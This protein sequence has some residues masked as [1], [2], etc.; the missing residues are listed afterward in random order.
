MEIITPL[1][2]P[3]GAGLDFGE[4]DVRH[5]SQGDALNTPGLSNPTRY[6]AQ[7][8]NLMTGKVNELVAQV[9]NRE[10]FVPL[11]IM[12]TILPR[13]TET[14]VTNYR[15]PVGFEARV[16]NAAVASTPASQDVVLSISYNSTY[17]GSTGDELVST[18]GEYANGGGSFSAAGELIVTLNNRSGLTLEVIASVMLTIRPVGAEAA[19]LTGAVIQGP[20]GPPGP[21]GPPG[22]QGPAGTGGAGAPG[23]VWRGPWTDGASYVTNDVASYYY[24]GT[25]LSSFIARTPHVASVLNSPQVDATT[26]NPVALGGAQ[27][28]VGPAGPA[29]GDPTL[30]SSST[31][32]TFITGGDYVSGGSEQFGYAGFPAAST[33][34]PIQV[35]ETVLDTSTQRMSMLSNVFYTWFTGHGTVRLPQTGTNEGGGALDYNNTSIEVF[36]VDNG[37]AF[38]TAGTHSVQAYPLNDPRDFIVHVRDPQPVKVAIVINGVQVG[39]VP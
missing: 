20:Q 31:T 11:P 15:I 28:A 22:P 29:G 13:N 17:G 33:A 35:N 34:Y 32:G 24:N 19:V 18:S 39:S 37:T 25:A 12:R 3:T 7:R 5:F 21:K 2:L 38:P 4:G 16:L 30:Y 23:M 8:D 36:V 27:G 9:N 26:W 1:N 14:V 6:L 10:Q